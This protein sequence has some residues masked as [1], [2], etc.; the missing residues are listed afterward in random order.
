MPGEITRRRALRGVG[1]AL[2]VTAGTASAR[3][4]AAPAGI[5]AGDRESEFPKYVYQPG[6][7]DRWRAALPINVRVRAPGSR[8][9]LAGVRERFTGASGWRWTQFFPYSTARAWDGAAGELTPPDY[10]V[11]RPRPGDGWNHVHAWELDRDRVAMHAH[12]DVVDVDAE[13]LHSADDYRV[14][15]RQVRELFTSGGWTATPLSVEYDER[16]WGETGDTELRYR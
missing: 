12:L 1:S 11:R 16:D 15:T 5:S 3:R 8:R 7:G 10:S 14:A 9:A 6:E 4:D 2:V 13:Y